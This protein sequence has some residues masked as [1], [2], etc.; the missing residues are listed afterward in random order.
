MD[1]KKILVDAD[2]T[3]Q[4]RQK[5]KIDL[6]NKLKVFGHCVLA[7]CTGFGKT[8]LVSQM[9][10]EYNRVL[11]L[12]PAEVIKDTAMS[13]I[14]MMDGDAGRAE[15]D[16]TFEFRNI[17]FMTY[18]KL[19][20]L[21]EEELDD[22]KGKVDLIIMDEV[23]RTGA[24]KTS[25]AVRHLIDSFK[26]HIIGA[27][28]TPDRMDAMDFISEFFGGVCT[29]EYTLHD[30][31]QDGIIKR[32]IYCYCTYDVE[33]DL[34]DA[35]LT[36]GEDVNNITVKEVLKSKLVEIS[37]IYNMPNM[38]DLWLQQYP[39]AAGN[40]GASETMLRSRYEECHLM[41]CP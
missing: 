38:Q 20:R 33:T 24:K 21:S 16:E 3:A 19:I 25:D 28:A 35:A 30:A 32:P 41:I 14:E 17:K 12:Y 4:M 37:N 34:R 27:T 39:D 5:T 22:L 2:I 7:R 18:M 31:I 6:K 13:V 10:Q 36:A 8:W 26:G 11:Y 9:T 23:H 15:E 29:Y 1:N 40:D